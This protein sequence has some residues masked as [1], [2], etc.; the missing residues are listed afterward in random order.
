MLN[1]LIIHAFSKIPL[2]IRAFSVHQGGVQTHAEHGASPRKPRRKQIKPPPPLTVR[3]RPRLRALPA[4][5]RERPP[6]F[7]VA[8]FKAAGDGERGGH[9]QPSRSRSARPLRSAANRRRGRSRPF[10]LCAP[11]LAGGCGR[12]GR[13]RA[14]RLAAVAAGAPARSARTAAVPD[15][16]PV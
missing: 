5:P 10:A 7:H 6:R 12:E 14:R 13:G 2:I 3:A 4:K 8:T 9:A 15:S 11:P 16:F 1:H